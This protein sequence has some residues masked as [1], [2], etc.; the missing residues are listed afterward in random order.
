MHSKQQLEAIH[1]RAAL[2]A[3][4]RVKQYAAPQEVPQ[5]AVPRAPMV[6]PARLTK[7]EWGVV[8]LIAGGMSNDEIAVYLGLSTETIKSHVRHVLG[9]L[10]AKNR[11]H[12]VGI[13]YREMAVRR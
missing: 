9:K 8:E 4:A 6:T 10:G 3:R 11:A 2:R 12:A 7:R 5:H 13:L 1:R